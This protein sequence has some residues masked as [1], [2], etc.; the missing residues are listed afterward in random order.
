MLRGV[1][2]KIK[3]DFYE[4]RSRRAFIPIPLRLPLHLSGSPLLRLFQ[5]HPTAS[6]GEDENNLPFSAPTLYDAAKHPIGPGMIR[7]L[8]LADGWTADD[9]PDV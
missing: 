1:F 8:P 9:L 3:T 7:K 2:G 4:G 6:I 5:A